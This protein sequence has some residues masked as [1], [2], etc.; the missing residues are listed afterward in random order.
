MVRNLPVRPWFY[1]KGS[2]QGDILSTVTFNEV[3]SFNWF[4]AACF[5]SAIL[6]GVFNG[7]SV[8]VWSTALVSLGFLLRAAFS[9]DVGK[10]HIINHEY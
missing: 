5:L 2:T 9:G 10:S 7:E 4:I 3:S 1:T 8:G 6:Y